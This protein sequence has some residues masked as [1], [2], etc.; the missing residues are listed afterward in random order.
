MSPENIQLRQQINLV[1]GAYSRLDK[2]SVYQ[3]QHSSQGWGLVCKQSR[4]KVRELVS[5]LFLAT[6]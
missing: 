1:D 3:I 4:P 5:P 2:S 6:G